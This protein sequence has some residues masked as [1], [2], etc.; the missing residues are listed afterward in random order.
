MATSYSYPDTTVTN[1]NTYYY[2]VAGYDL[3]GTG[4]VLGTQA[5]VSAKPMAGL[6][7]T[8]TPVGAIGAIPVALLLGGALFYQ[9]RRRSVRR[10]AATTA[11]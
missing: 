11:S 3:S 10:A 7:G 5:S 2:E 9:Q 8:Q 1:G 6:C 4:Y